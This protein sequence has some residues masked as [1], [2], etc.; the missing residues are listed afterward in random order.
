VFKGENVEGEGGP[1]RQFF[2]DV[3]KELQGV[4]PLLIPCP[5][6]QAKV[7]YNRDKWIPSPSCE[8][9]QHLAMYEF[10]GRL[11]GVA[12]RTGVLLTLDLP[13]F[14]WKP[15]VG[16]PASRSDLKQIDYSLYGFLKYIRACERLDFEGDTRKIFEKYSTSLSDKTKVPLRDGGEETDLYYDNRE[17]YIKLVEHVRLHESDRQLSAIRKGLVSVVPASLL[18]LM[19]WQDLEW[20]VCGRPHVDV[21]LLRRHTEYSSISP[22]SSHVYYLWQTLSELGQQDLRRFL[23][24]AWAQERLPADD[25]EFIR[26]QTRMLIK[27]ASVAPNVDPNSMFPQADTCFFNLTLPEYSSQAI[28]K[29]KLLFAI[30]TDADSMDADQPQEEGSGR[31]TSPF[32]NDYSDSDSE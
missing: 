1:Y 3:S 14:V 8:S 19:T 2:T 28:L 10:L 29:D 16:I 26:T 12:M 4:L 22:E 27:P 30:N 11:M 6:A 7:G 20:R 5:N 21:A 17:E 31:L 32:T 25:Q 24:F 15:L 13:S 9:S 23:R 18:A